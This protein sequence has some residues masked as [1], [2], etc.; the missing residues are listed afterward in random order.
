MI[1]KNSQYHTTE[2]TLSLPFGGQLPCHMPDCRVCQQCHRDFYRKEIS[3]PSFLFPDSICPQSSNFHCFVTNI[4]LLLF[5]KSLTIHTWQLF[6]APAPKICAFFAPRSR[7]KLPYS[8]VWVICLNDE[9][10]SPVGSAC[11][12]M[13]LV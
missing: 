3:A 13:V 8:T 7:R 12:I 9:T 11:A 5:L 10:L 4:L 2:I 1:S 6:C